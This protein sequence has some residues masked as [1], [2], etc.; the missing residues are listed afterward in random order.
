MLKE[1]KLISFCIGLVLV[2]VLQKFATPEPVFRFL[3]PAFL[4]YASVVFI[5]N[6]WYLKQ[7]QKYSIWV[8]LRAMLLLAGA[9]GLFL[10]I[11]TESFRAFYLVVTVALI[12]F[13]EAMLGKEGE[14]ILLNETLVIAFGLFIFF[15]AS[16]QYVPVYGPL[17]AV[18]VFVSAVLLSRSFY[19]LVPQ[20]DYSKLISSVVLGLFCTEFFW[21]LSFLPFHFSIQG[22][23]LFNLFYLCL[24]LNYYHQFHN[25]N[26]KKI[27]F[28]LLLI[29][30]C[31]AVALLSTPW[32]IIQ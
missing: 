25:L 22:I 28:H 4:L 24:I 2:I 17:Y 29:L 30:A 32:K 23:F 13:G 20:A 16:Y 1:H 7:I 3:L 14:N 26:L 9:F 5:Y 15:S 19:E 8:G 27:Q 10:I 21:A 18:G 6:R 11:P 12:W 31:S